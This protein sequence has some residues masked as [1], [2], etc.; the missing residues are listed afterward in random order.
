MGKIGEGKYHLV[1]LASSKLQSKKGLSIVIKTFKQPKDSDGISRTAIREIMATKPHTMWNYAFARPVMSYNSI[2]RKEQ[3]FLLGF[4]KALLLKTK[5]CDQSFLRSRP[6]TIASLGG[7]SQLYTSN[8]IV[9]TTLVIPLYDFMVF[10]PHSELSIFLL[11]FPRENQEHKR[12]DYAHTPQ[13]KLDLEGQKRVKHRRVIHLENN[14]A[15]T[16]GEVNHLRC[17]IEER[18]SMSCG[19]QQE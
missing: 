2:V 13:L 1:F 18:F 9:R 16:R 12:N 11:I 6:V 14:L 5:V 8:F 3:V 19:G 4:A 15:I 7:S 10:I 17:D